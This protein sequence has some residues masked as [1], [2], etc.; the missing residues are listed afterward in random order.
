VLTNKHIVITGGSR[1]IGL[2]VAQNC[3]ANGA[4]VTLI[5]RTAQEL[6]NAQRS[7]SDIKSGSVH[8]ESADVSDKT[9][10]KSAIDKSVKKFGSIYGLIC[11]A[12]V[13]G[14]IGAFT[15]GSIEEWE[16]GLD[17]N[18]K[19]TAYSVYHSYPHFEKND[20]RIILFSGGGQGP[21]E[22]FSCYVTSKGGIWRFTE[23]VGAELVRKNIYMNAIAPGAVNT[24]FLDQ[25][26]KAGPEKVGKQFYEKSLKQ[27][28]DGGQSP[29]KAADL[30]LYLL[31]SKSKG[32]WGK[33]LSAVWDPYNDF[34]NLEDI[35][36]SDIYSYRR[37]V[38]KNGN[39]RSK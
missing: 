26:I 19:G 39:T 8:I 38:D 36:N 25:L 5:S 9:S 16:K 34:S 18:L 23:T 28:E 33:T 27:K 7:L 13:Y 11:G 21:L 35:S 37:V 2:T 1:G 29:Q 22:N 4:N 14:S 20:G 6:E 17:I 12:G 3:K 31:S 10:I 32:L 15:E 30:C 24:H